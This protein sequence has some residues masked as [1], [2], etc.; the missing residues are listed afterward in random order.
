MIFLDSSFFIAL[1][2]RKDQWH[3][4][5]AKLAQGLPEDKLVT[6]LV[7]SEGVTSVGYL[8]GGKA[9]LSLYEYIA[10]NCEVVFV[11]KEILESSLEIYL[12][13]DGT[14]SLTDAISVH[15]MRRKGIKEIASFDSDFD[16]VKD[17]IRVH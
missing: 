9:G 15:V 5:A 16:K 13:F 14:L 1:A 6:D 12:K 11:D 2:N 17:L 10:G 8:G 3:D 4:R 7:I